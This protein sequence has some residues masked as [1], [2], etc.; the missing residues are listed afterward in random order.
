MTKAKT[1]KRTEPG[2]YKRVDGR[3]GYEVR[4]RWTCRGGDEKTSKRHLPTVIY[5]FDPRAKSGPS[6]EA[7]AL[8]NAN[9]YAIQQWAA[10][11]F[12][13]KPHA[14]LADGWTLGQLLE[15]LLGEAVTSIEEARARG[16]PAPQG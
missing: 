12:Y 9:A 13:D 4:I 15:R 11:R 14:E 3:P 10:I 2:V 5:P 7:A 1:K 6:C 8:A 16:L